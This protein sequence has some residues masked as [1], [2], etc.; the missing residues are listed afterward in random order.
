MPIHAVAADRSTTADPAKLLEMV[1]RWC[2]AAAVEVPIALVTG[3]IQS[4]ASGGSGELRLGLLEEF[5]L[6]IAAQ[7]CSNSQKIDKLKKETARMAGDPLHRPK[8]RP[9]HPAELARAQFLP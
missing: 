5:V 7:L 1:R 3:L 8:L 4:A 9:G 2:P 6:G